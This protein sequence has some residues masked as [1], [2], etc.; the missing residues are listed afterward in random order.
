MDGT[1]RCMVGSFISVRRWCW[2]LPGVLFLGCGE[3]PGFPTGYVFRPLVQGSL[4]FRNANGEITEYAVDDARTQEAAAVSTAECHATDHG[5]LVD[6]SDTN[7]GRW[8]VGEA[9]G[10]PEIV[11]DGGLPRFAMQDFGAE[12]TFFP[13]DW[14]DDLGEYEGW[15]G[16]EVTFRA[17]VMEQSG[18]IAP[19]PRSMGHVDYESIPRTTPDYFRAY[20]ISGSFECASIPESG[21]DGTWVLDVHYEQGPEQV[22]WIYG[23]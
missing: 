19:L 21:C 14:P 13:I 9:T 3:A 20:A 22:S 23:N 8:A 16:A 12:S 2:G 4:E 5:I 11:C 1:L 10:A 17:A 7:S 15:F 6:F 18:S